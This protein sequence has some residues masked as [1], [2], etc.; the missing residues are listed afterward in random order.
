MEKVELGLRRT[1]DMVSCPT[2]LVCQVTT[3]TNFLL[4][5]FSAPRS[6]ATCFHH[7]VR[8]PFSSRSRLLEGMHVRN[9]VLRGTRVIC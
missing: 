9:Q 3:T 6:L 1:M 7:R 4:P 8:S 5:A 2:G